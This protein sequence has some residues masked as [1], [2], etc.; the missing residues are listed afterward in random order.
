MM[1]KKIEKL[2]IRDVR[3]WK[4]EHTFDFEDGINLIKGPNGSGKSTIWLCIA[5]GLTHSA[6]SK[7]LKEQLS[8]NTGGLPIITVNF[9]T[10]D[11]KR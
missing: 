11:G 2:I 7:K 6:K 3:K 9:Q 8:P 5:L 4:G 1:L 10:N